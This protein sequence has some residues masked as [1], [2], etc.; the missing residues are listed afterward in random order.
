[1]AVVMNGGVSLAV[2]RWGPT[3]VALLGDDTPQGVM[4]TCRC[5]ELLAAAA[6]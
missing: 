4:P 3:G 1:M 2:D 6:K 5:C